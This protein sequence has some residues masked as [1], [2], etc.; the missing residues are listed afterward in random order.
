MMPLRE[1]T[2]QANTQPLSGSYDVTLLD[3]DGVI[4]LLEEAIAGAEEA[5]QSLRRQGNQPVFV[6][7]N[8]SRLAGEVAQLL[9]DVG[10]KASA[11]EVQTSAQTAVE[12]IADRLRDHSPR[13]VLVT[14]SAALA[15]EVVEAGLSPTQDPLQAGAVVQGYAPSLG[16]SDLADAAIAI[17]QGALWVATNTDATLPSPHGP[18][19][20]N[21]SL[22]N[23]VAMA[24]ERRPDIIAGK[25]EPVIYQQVM[26]R[27]PGEKHIAVGDRWDTDIAGANAAGIDSMLVFTGV[28][29]PKSALT[30]PAAGRPSF[31]GRSVADILRGQPEVR[32]DAEWTVCCEDWTASLNESQNIMLSG[33]GEPLDA[34]RALCELSWT[35]IDAAKIDGREAI[36]SDGVDADSVVAQVN[37]AE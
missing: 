16:W 13:R 4:Y 31:L 10:V 9:T 17:R 14:G 27:F 26:D 33:S 6:T 19:P 30:I 1:P 22:V 37:A 18:L 28:T 2:L 29:S 15:E 3:L 7:N 34:W 11:V 35:A 25:P 20:G 36:D 12:L 5:V 24:V 32:W 23:A 8:A 21:G